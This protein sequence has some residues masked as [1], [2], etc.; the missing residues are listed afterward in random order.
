[1]RY[2]L[3][4]ILSLVALNTLATNTIKNSVVT[5]VTIYRSYAKETRIGS[6][7]VP[8]GNSE[9]VITNITQHIDENSIQVGCRSDIKL[10]SVSTRLNYIVD[11]HGINPNKIKVWQ[12]SI[13]LLDKKSR[14]MA[15]QKEAYETELSILNANT[16]LGSEHEGL[17]AAHLKELLDLNRSK[18]AELKKLIFDN[19]EYNE[20]R[21]LM[22]TLQNQVNQHS[23]N[24][25]GKPVREIVLKLFSNSENNTS[26]KVSYLVTTA[27][28]T[29]TYELRCENTNKPLMINC[30][31]KI[32]QNTG[33][34]WKNARIKLSTANPTQ[35]HN[36]PILYPLFV[37]FMQPDYYQAK[38]KKTTGYGEDYVAKEAPAVQMM[39][40]MAY[41][42]SNEEFKDGM[43][44]DEKAVTVTEGDMMVE[45]ELEQKQDIE[46][47]G[48]EHIV[49]I[50]EIA[51][52]ATYNY[53]TVPKLDNGV[54]LLAR[55]TD[56]GKYN[57][58]AGEATLFFDDMYIGK[59]YLNP[60]VSTDTLL[61][62]LGRD[63]KINVKRTKLLELC[64]TKKFSSKKKEVKAYETM[65]KNNKNIPIEIELLDQI[66]LAR[67][68]DIEVEL[69]EAEGAEITKEYGKVL[70]KLKLQPGETRKVKIVYSI[71]F[72]DDKR[73]VEKN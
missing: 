34:D 4:T 54:F 47:D 6:I 39:S 32:T 50:Q 31:A 60:H 28:W 71:K 73:V 21:N 53:H 30:R 12:D 3:C 72:P 70:W 15:K 41:G 38:L 16:K 68:T 20:Y 5:D 10:L 7:Q 2:L 11:E 19:E 27:G 18:Q 55:V 8:E 48:K 40:N 57:L 13:K 35:N 44:L 51:L 61:I 65:I 52:P 64:S 23:T 69:E 25:M 45:Y 58:L 43:K 66:P 37:D 33:F 22:A 14:F 67:H 26:F 24:A 29:P 59:S 62:S 63:E 17:K 49:A 46:S 42:K 56:W 36:R 1:M 9:V